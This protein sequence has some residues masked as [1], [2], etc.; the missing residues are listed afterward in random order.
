MWHTDIG[1][2]GSFFTFLPPHPH[3]TAKNQKN[4]NFEKMKKIAGDIIIFT[5]VYQKLQSEFFVLL[6]HFL[7]F[8]PPNNLENQNFEKM[9]K[10]SG[11]FIIL[12]MYQK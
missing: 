5:H 9:K 12:Q 4:H 10:A 6:G 7:P 1:N 11:E 8:Y 3:P 2:Y